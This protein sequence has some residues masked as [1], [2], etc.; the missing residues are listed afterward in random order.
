LF[1]IFGGDVVL[2]AQCDL[3]LSGGRWELRGGLGGGWEA[4][5]SNAFISDT[6]SR[7]ALKLRGVACHN[8]GHVQG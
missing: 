3:A 7:M 5:F 6:P 4:K 8:V 1:T 2:V